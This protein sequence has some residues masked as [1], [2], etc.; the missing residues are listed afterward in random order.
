[1][2]GRTA[3]KVGAK[4]V[5]NVAAKEFFQEGAK[6]VAKQVEKKFA[7][8]ALDV[9]SK[10]AGGKAVIA[11]LRNEAIEQLGAKASKAEIA[12][13]VGRKAVTHLHHGLARE[14]STASHKAIHEL[15]TKEGIETLTHE[16]VKAIHREVTGA[17]VE[18]HLK[19]LNLDGH[20]SD[21]ALELLNSVR[22]KKVSKA[23]AELAEALGISQ[24]E[25]VAMAKKAR[26]ALMKGKSDDAIK[27]ELSAGISKHF[28]DILK[29]DMEHA[30]KEQSQKILRGQVDEPWAKELSESVE[31]RAQQLGKSKDE[32]VDEFV[33]A[34]WSGAKEGIE[35]AV[36]KV[37][38]EGIDDAFKRFRQ[39]KI[40]GGF[41]DAEAAPE[42]H[43]V[44][45]I[46][47]EEA[48]K[49]AAAIEAKAAEAAREGLGDMAATKQYTVTEGDEIITVSLA[50]DNKDNAYREVGRSRTSIKRDLEKDTKAKAA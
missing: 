5:L 7:K 8:E 42:L 50:F 13:L 24:K 40:R 16:N 26:S 25:G 34:G 43:A 39:A 22:D 14:A 15:V 47:A 27:E 44:E 37:V 6:T 4:Q 1:V 33:D 29:E 30:Y 38:R 45:E 12:D 21:A 10:E 9:L 2:T 35:K 23:G 31:K 3:F 36:G 41:G 17:A 18:K 11:Q 49:A 48:T 32:L 20:V 28:S 46:K 19:A